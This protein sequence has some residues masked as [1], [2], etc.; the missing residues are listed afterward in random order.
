MEQSHSGG[1]N[2]GS[3]N[4]I[5]HLLRNLEVNYQEPAIGPYL[6]PD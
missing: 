4:E 6:E 2:N 3:A 1:A 5:P